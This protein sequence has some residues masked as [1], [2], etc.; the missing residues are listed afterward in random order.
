[1]VL[2]YFADGARILPDL[3]CTEPGAE[4]TG[5]SAQVQ[6]CVSCGRCVSRVNQPGPVALLLRWHSVGLWG[7]DGG[8]AALR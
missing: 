2:A 8:D 3:Y 4:P 1:M 7:G 6:V 5:T